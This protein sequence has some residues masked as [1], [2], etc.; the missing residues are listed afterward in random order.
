MNIQNGF[1]SL[2][3]GISLAIFLCG[4]SGFSIF[5][6]A[7]LRTILHPTTNIII[8]FIITIANVIIGF[9]LSGAV[10]IL[11]FNISS[12]LVSR[13]LPQAIRLNE[14]MRLLHAK[15]NAESLTT[16]TF[17]RINVFKTAI[18]LGDDIK[19]DVKCRPLTTFLAPWSSRSK[20][21]AAL[22]SAYYCCDYSQIQ[23][24]ISENQAKWGTPN[25]NSDGKDARAEL[26]QKLAQ[27][28]EEKKKV[29]QELTAA[30]GREALLKRQLQESKAHMAVLVELAHQTTLAI[31]PPQSLTREAI[32]KRYADLA[33]QH[34]LD[35]TPREYVEI[36]RTAMPK[37]YINSGGAP[38]QGSPPS[39]T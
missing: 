16:L 9:F 1:E 28:K 39:K 10:S 12:F 19:Y 7:Y 35:S 15:T 25:S 21:D 27:L 36:F 11:I 33:T 37:E 8:V 29:T 24:I 14:A 17:Y 13:K 23:K 38:L 26:Q 4:I 18:Q 6:T 22:G 31:K 3:L 30:T 2:R 5:S 32:K 34:G 20:Q